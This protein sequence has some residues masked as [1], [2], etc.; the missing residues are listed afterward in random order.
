MKISFTTKSGEVVGLEQKGEEIVLTIASPNNGLD[1]QSAVLDRSCTYILTQSLQSM[2]PK[3]SKEE[4]HY[5]G[6]CAK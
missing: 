5:P 3:D 6:R 1:N 2:A 4:V